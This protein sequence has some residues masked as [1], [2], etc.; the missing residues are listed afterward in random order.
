MSLRLADMDN[1]TLAEIDNI[2]LHELDNMSYQDL[3]NTVIAKYR[4]AVKT[5]NP[6]KTLS[7]AQRSAVQEI[8]H[9]YIKENTPTLAKSITISVAIDAIGHFLFFVINKVAEHSQEVIDSLKQA[10]I[11]LLQ[12]I[13]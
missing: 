12:L 2:A 1:F 8:I 10:Y 3:V 4:L 11:L 9:T 5:C 7:D 13:E 6:S